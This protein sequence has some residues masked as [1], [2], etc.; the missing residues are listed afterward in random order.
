MRVSE[1]PDRRYQ[2]QPKKANIRQCRQCQQANPDGS[3][4]DCYKCGSTEH[5]ASGCRKKNVS[6]NTSKIEIM[7]RPERKMDKERPIIGFIV[8]EE[9]ALRSETVKTVSLQV[10]W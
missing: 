9:L 3:C 7:P 5:W 10:T 6:A 1:R 4:D 8:I 2:P